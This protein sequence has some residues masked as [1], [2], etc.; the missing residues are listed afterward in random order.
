LSTLDVILGIGAGL[1]VNEFCDISPWAAKRIVVWS[2]RLQYG[3]SSRAEIRAE[4]LCAV[5]DTRP[6]KLFKLITALAFVCGAAHAYLYREMLFLALY[7]LISGA[8][9]NMSTST[10]VKPHFR[11]LRDGRLVAVRAHRRRSRQSILEGKLMAVIEE[12]KRKRSVSD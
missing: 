4:E 11:R 6:G 10:L 5:I 1:L 2:S 3:K 9:T 8:G 7:F 12:A